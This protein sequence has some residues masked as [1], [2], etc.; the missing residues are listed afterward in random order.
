MFYV[1]HPNIELQWKLKILGLFCVV[2]D[3][4]KYVGIVKNRGRVLVML[5]LRLSLTD[6]CSLL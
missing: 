5:R 2:A 6:A 1:K 3:L 4:L